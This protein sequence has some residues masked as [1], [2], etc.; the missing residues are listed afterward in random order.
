MQYSNGRM[1]AKLP[2]KSYRGGWFLHQSWPI[3]TT[4]TDASNTGIGAVL[5]ELDEEGRERARAFGSRVL[6]KP[7]RQYYVTRRDLLA[8]VTFIRH[9]QSFLLGC[10]FTLRTDHG[11]LT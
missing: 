5:S 7:E 6:S 11:S 3:Q 1:N 2:S 10:P 4:D 9:F 8:V